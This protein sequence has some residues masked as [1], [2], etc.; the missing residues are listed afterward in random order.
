M[1]REKTQIEERLSALRQA[2]SDVPGAWTGSG[3]KAQTLKARPR[4]YRAILQRRRSIRSRSRRNRSP[5]QA[6]QSNRHGHAPGLIIE[7]HP[8]PLY[9]LASTPSPSRPSSPSSSACK[10]CPEEPPDDSS[11]SQRDELEWRFW[12]QLRRQAY[13]G[14]SP[15]EPT[16][17]TGP[18]DTES[19]PSTA[20]PQ[21]QPRQIHNLT[22]RSLHSRA[23]T[24]A[25]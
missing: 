19:S 10:D 3:Q 11:N 14:C 15:Y 1:E 12:Q 16:G 25:S 17:N 7:Y 2:P 23:N 22:I 20:R 8:S 24:P 4:Q 18:Q 5:L 6:T 13:A 21:T 9:I